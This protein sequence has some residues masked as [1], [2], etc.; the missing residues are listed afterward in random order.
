MAD[1]EKRG[2]LTADQASTLR[3]LGYLFFRMGQFERARRLFAAMAALDP[4]DRWAQRNL[5]AAALAMGDGAAAL[6]HLR[7]AVNDGMLSTADAALHLLRARALWVEGR[8][9]EAR[10]AVEA[11]LAATGSIRSGAGA[12]S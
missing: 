8:R 2:G 9:D 6:E 12:G 4:D 3:V 11:Y 7:R 10:S 5:A 1:E